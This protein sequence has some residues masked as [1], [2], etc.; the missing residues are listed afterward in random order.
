MQKPTIGILGC[1]WLGLPLAERLAASGYR[2]RGTTTTAARLDLLRSAGI[3]PFRV[4][5]GEN[6]EG[7]LKG[8]LQCDTLIVD[9]PP[10][11]GQDA[12]EQ[13]IVRISCLI[14]ALL[15]SP[16]RQVL[17]VSATSV[18]PALNREVTELD[19]TDPDAADSPLG[20]AL[21]Y[22]EE[23]LRSES[24]FRTTVVRFS[25]LVGPDRNPAR[26][27]QR[28]QAV[29]DPDQPMNLIHR[30]DCIGVIMSIIEKGL[31]GEVFNASCELHPKRREFYAIA[32]EALGLPLPDAT[33]GGTGAPFKTVGSRKLIAATGYR[34]VHPD[35]LE[36]ARSGV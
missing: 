26:Y 35:P 12:V 11:S 14:D 16:V 2:V 8:F 31:W 30:D 32:A 21:L 9:I 19:A 29:A 22:V 7:D 18:Y 28:M 17:F 23:M 20:R 10:D 3:E 24:S 13:Y 4:V 34:F 6:P 33:A 15:D 5:L 25:G 27:L 1:G 36:M